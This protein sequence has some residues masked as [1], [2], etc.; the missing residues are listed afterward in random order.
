MMNTPP[1]ASTFLLSHR[2]LTLDTV[3]LFAALTIL[4]VRP[5]LTTIPMHDFW[6]HLAMGREIATTGTIP[7]VD[8]FSFTR[9]DEPFFNQ[10]WLAQLCM[11][12]LYVLGGLPLL[13]LV[14]AL[15]IVGTYGLLLHLCIVRTG[16]LRLCV[17]LM[18]LGTVPAS[19]TNWVIRPQSYALPLF[20]IF[21]YVLTAWGL[22][23]DGALAREFR[24]GGVRIPMLWLLPVLAV[25]W[26][27][28][29]G[30]FVLGG[31]LIFLTFI[32]EWLRR[33]I[34][35]RQEDLS[36]AQRPVGRAEDVLE[37]LERPQRPPLSS[38]FMCG[39]LV[40]GAWLLNPQGLEVIGYV[41]NLL[42]SSQVTQ[43]VTE[44]A[45]P[46]IRDASG[47]LFFLFV[48]GGVLI[49]A[50][51]R[52]A[53][54][55][56]DMLLLAAFF[57]LALSAIRNNIWFAL[58]ATPL[59]AVQAASWREQGTAVF[60][61][62]PKLNAMLIGVLSLLLLL[63]SPWVKPNLGL[64]PQLGA[65]VDPTTPV[66]A[67]ETLRSDQAR[68]QRVFHDLGY[69][70]YLIWAMPEQL[71][72]IDPRIELYPF[73][74]WQD[75]LQLSRGENVEALLERYD[76][77]GLLLDQVY[78]KELVAWARSD[79]RWELRYEDDTTV[80]FAHR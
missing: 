6:W 61:G 79:E 62:Q 38:L 4:A 80:Y 28:V 43:L 30:S 33:A 46:T 29:H 8:A 11:Y 13:I 34:S 16:R 24:L 21:L 20:A 42:G 2:L 48:M 51:A 73:E 7:A 78:Q 37:R 58:V 59:Y 14:Q 55:P 41:R 35:D 3:Y 18:L 56:V 12:G 76:I 47:A 23:R 15:V 75:F 49:L 1:R 53:P 50:Y 44:W 19:F 60:Q 39:M 17:G 10:S 40:G 77:D 32:G 52:R 27:N 72:F 45:P 74:Q 66:A 9:V 26:V 64:P 22:G 68:P 5:L 57:W 31:V 71:V 69:G 54:D 65:L 25:L 36:W 63:S 70:S 67:V